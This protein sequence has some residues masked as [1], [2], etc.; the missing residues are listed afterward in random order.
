MKIRIKGNAL[1]LRLTK[2]EVEKLATAGYLEERTNFGNNVLTY[3][4][5]VTAQGDDLT[6][7]F[8]GNQITVFI[9]GAWAQTWPH[10]NTTGFNS[11][12][13]V[14]DTEKLSLLVEKDFKCLDNAEE[15]QGEFY[16][17]PNKNC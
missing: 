10:N 7:D 5:H 12:V 17:N 14:S 16:E 11:A 9:P 1:R 8:D 3:A 15:D 6:A 13:Q 4:L 2:P